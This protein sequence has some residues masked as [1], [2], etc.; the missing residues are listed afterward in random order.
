MLDKG[1][2]VILS[3]LAGYSVDGRVDGRRG[4]IRQAILRGENIGY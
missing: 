3:K 1:L 2:L 4:V